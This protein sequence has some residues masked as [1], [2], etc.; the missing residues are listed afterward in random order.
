V[1]PAKARIAH[2]FGKAATQYESQAQI[3]AWAAEQLGQWLADLSLPAGPV[4]E[5]GCGTGLFSR[6]LLSRLPNHPIHLQDLSPAML[7]HCRQQ[8]GDLQ[9]QISFDC[10]DGEDPLVDRYCLIASSFTIQWFEDPGRAIAQWGEA[11]LPGG[12]LLL[13]FPAAGSFPEW[14]AA[15]EQSGIPYTGL[16]LPELDGL[17][18][19]LGDRLSLRR[20]Q[21]VQ[22]SQPLTQPDNF[23]R[24]LRGI[25]AHTSGK[26]LKLRQ[27]R[28]LLKAWPHPTATYS[29]ALVTLQRPQ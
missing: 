17:I 20:K 10:R 25:G 2:N 26:T 11:L 3:Q 12:Y 22:I 15:C 16:P 9:A 29:T 21:L 23:F 18:A 13:A 24:Q 1:N 7:D 27:F 6:Q 28:Q 4:L 5:V 8:V 19:S 14:R